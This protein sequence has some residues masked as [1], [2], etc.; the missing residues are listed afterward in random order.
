MLHITMGEHKGNIA[1][2]TPK[3]KKLT[4]S[5]S[6]PC[7]MCKLHDD[8]DSIPIPNYRSAQSSE[9][10]LIPVPA[11]QQF[12]PPNPPNISYLYLY[13]WACVSHS[14]RTLKLDEPPFLQTTRREIHARAPS[15]LMGIMNQSIGQPTANSFP[16]HNLF[17]LLKRKY[18]MPPVRPSHKFLDRT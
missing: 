17:V 4:L 18:R 15:S 9:Y 3:S 6:S 10:D 2:S 5:H 1:I 7:N 13:P 11:S 12:P 16:S 14:F 8:F